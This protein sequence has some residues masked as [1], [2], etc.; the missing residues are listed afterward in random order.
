[1]AAV[2]GKRET[3]AGGL[4]YRVQWSGTTEES[5]EPIHH[6]YGSMVMVAQYEV[7]HDAAQGEPEAQRGVPE[8]RQRA[9]DMGV[10]DGEEKRWQRA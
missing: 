4:E 8:A 1:M 3:A 5:W 2:V 10:R 6:L 7:A 9:R